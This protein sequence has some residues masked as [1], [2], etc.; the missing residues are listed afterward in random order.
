MIGRRAV[1]P[2]NGRRRRPAIPDGPAGRSQSP[3]A[4]GGLA[5]TLVA[6]V[7]QASSGAAISNI[8]S[9]N[10]VLNWTRGLKR[11]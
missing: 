2:P 11:N 7:D 9:I 6:N 1:K 5:G 3:D 10:V 4:G 8:G